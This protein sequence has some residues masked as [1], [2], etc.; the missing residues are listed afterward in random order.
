MDSRVLAALVMDA[1]ADGMR[2]T[3]GLNMSLVGRQ[4]RESESNNES[5][6]PGYRRSRHRCDCLYAR[7]GLEIWNYSVPC[8][9]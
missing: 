3:L 2:R 9:R 8:R 4:M 6:R 7:S 5:H 1:F